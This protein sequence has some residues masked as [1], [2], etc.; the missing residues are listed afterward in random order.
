MPY[1]GP[2]SAYGVIGQAEAAVLRMVNAEGGIR[3]RRVELLSADDGYSP[4]RTV[5]ETRRLVESEG[6]AFLY[7]GLGTA[8]QAAVQRYLNQRGYVMVLWTHEVRGK[9]AARR[10]CA[11]GQ[12]TSV[13][14]TKADG[15]ERTPRD[16]RHR[17][18]LA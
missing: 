16:W 8:T 17:S 9:P 1:S 2:A 4:P 14:G 6:V 3:G 11:A 10:T 13:R 15:L 5:E 7:Q 18:R 12:A